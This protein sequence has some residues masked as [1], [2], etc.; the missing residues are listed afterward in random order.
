MTVTSSQVF[1]RTERKTGWV[2]IV[3]D[4]LRVPDVESRRAESGLGS[5]EVDKKVD[6]YPGS[7]DR[8]E[9]RFHCSANILTVLLLIP[10]RPRLLPRYLDTRC[11]AAGHQC[12]VARTASPD[13]M[14]RQWDGTRLSKFDNMVR[15]AVRASPA[16]LR[17]ADIPFPRAS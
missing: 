12:A 3:D 17:E 14:R 13:A 2:S 7:H 5:R 15:M 10:F 6:T 4:C 1:D 9:V 8:S 16:C 11:R